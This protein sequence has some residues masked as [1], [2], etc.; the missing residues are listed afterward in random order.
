MLETFEMTGDLDP[1]LIPD[2]SLLQYM[3]FFCGCVC[4]CVCVC[5]WVGGW[6]GGV[7]SL[8]GG[9]WCVRGG[10]WGMYTTILLKG[11]ARMS[12]HSLSN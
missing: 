4:V 2:E 11:Q 10:L 1:E 8:C 5:V 6:V 12:P 3:V 9:R 7:V